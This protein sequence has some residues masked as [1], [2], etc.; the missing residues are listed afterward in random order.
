MEF[1]EKEIN[2]VKASGGTEL[3]QA[4]LS[5]FQDMS[6]FIP[7]GEKLV[8][9]V[10]MLSDGQPTDFVRNERYIELA[11]RMREGG[12]SLITLGIGSSYNEDLLTSLAEYSGGTW[13]HI[14]SSADIP[15]IFSDRLEEARTVIKV[16]PDIQIILTKDASMYEVYKSVPE[17]YLVK[18]INKK[19]N[20][21]TIPLSDILAGEQ[22]I[23]VAS[24]NIPPRPEGIC[25]LA[26]VQIADEPESKKEIIVT[27]TSDSNVCNIENNAFPRGIFLSS[28]TQVLTRLGIS[29]DR[30]ALSEA[31]K[32]A[33]TVLRDNSLTREKVV[34]DATIKAKETI[35]KSK[36]GLS[37]EELKIAKEEMT[38]IRRSG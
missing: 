33:E 4:L 9:R 28:K 18:D 27:Y 35:Q 7:P 36:H 29:G 17:V 14:A 1:V 21:Y 34:L 25:R 38:R 2:N 26:Q 30:N 12:V 22:Q 19:G 11:R 6:S 24:L 37:D 20:E 10:I 31:E 15:S 13:K 23:L 5:A 16:L 3:Y 32:Q 8:K